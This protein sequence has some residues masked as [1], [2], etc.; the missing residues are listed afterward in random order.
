MIHRDREKSGLIPG[1]VTTMT[2]MNVSRSAQFAAVGREPM[3]PSEYRTRRI[4]VMMTKIA[5]VKRTD[6]MALCNGSI[7]AANRMGIGMAMMP[8]S[9]LGRLAVANNF[10]IYTY[11]MLSAPTRAW[12]SFRR[13]Q[14]SDMTV[15][16]I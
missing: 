6:R 13:T 9:H 15:S 10:R 2:D 1:A 8:I 12:F 5:D 7:L 14:A 16:D 4:T 11:R 3:S